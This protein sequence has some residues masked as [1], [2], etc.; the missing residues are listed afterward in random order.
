M[1]RPSAYHFTW[2][3]LHWQDQMNHR[4]RTY[5]SGKGLELTNCFLERSLLVMNFLVLMVTAF[6][7]MAGVSQ[8]SD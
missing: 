3:L 7:D 1:T 8:R 4:D 6:S 5:A 2:K